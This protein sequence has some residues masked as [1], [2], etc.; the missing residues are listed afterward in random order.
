MLILCFEEFNKEFAIDNKAMSI[1]KIEDIG[2]DISL[3]RI[4][5]VMRDRAQLTINNN[6]SY[7]IINLHPTD[8]THWV[9]V[10]RRRSGNVH[11]FDS[12]GVETPPL[13]LKDYVD[14][15]SNERKQ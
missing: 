1:I 9:L 4:E 2:K 11:Y 15:G 6:N 7:I 8:D 12:F 3:T 14:M 5:V 10:I 13:F